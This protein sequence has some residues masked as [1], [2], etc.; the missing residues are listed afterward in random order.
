MYTPQQIGLNKQFRDQLLQRSYLSTIQLSNIPAVPVSQLAN[1]D[2]TVNVTPQNVGLV[3]GFWILVSYELTNTGASDATLTGRGAFNVLRRIQYY[4]LLNNWRVN[5]SGF[6]LALLN[7]AKIGWGFSG[8]YNPNLPNGIGQINYTV[9][10]RTATLA[11][12]TGDNTLQV[13][14]YVPLA[15]SAQDTTGAVF[16]QTT[17]GTQSLQLTINSTPGFT[18][19]DSIYGIYGG[20]NTAVTYK[21][22][23]SI[24]IQV[25][26]DYWGNIPYT[27]DKNGQYNYMV[28]AIDI[29]TSYLITDTTQSSPTVNQQF[30]FQIQNYRKFLSVIAFYDNFNSGSPNGEAAFAAGTDISSWMLQAANYTPIRTWSPTLLAGQNRNTLM[31]DMPKGGYLFDFRTQPLDSLYYGSLQITMTPSAVNS[32]GAYVYYGVET[33]AD[34]AIVTQSGSLPQ[35]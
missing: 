24:T 4:D 19:G 27:V 33:F 17:G 34:S 29:G 8:D 9:N 16:A 31:G 15:Y 7:S 3:K 25:F 21:T 32:A 28:P 1:G 26:Q 11:N 30:Q 22:G 35:H 12:T 20:A 5:T 13:L 23:T 2:Y 18:T 6:H 14:Y 10:N